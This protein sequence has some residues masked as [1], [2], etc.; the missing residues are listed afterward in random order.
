[1]R[2]NINIKIVNRISEK[3]I[4]RSFGVQTLRTKALPSNLGIVVFFLIH[5]YL[6][7]SRK[8]ADNIHYAADADIACDTFAFI[9]VSRPN[10]CN[11]L[12]TSVADS[13]TPPANITSKKSTSLLR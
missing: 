8:T 2:K 7:L 9:L 4:I 11:I 1:M 5:L 3:E 12:G 13:I 10:C 6:P